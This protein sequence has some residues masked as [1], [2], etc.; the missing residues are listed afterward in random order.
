MTSEG[1]SSGEGDETSTGDSS[2]LGAETDLEPEPLDPAVCDPHRSIEQTAGL[3]FHVTNNTSEQIVMVTRQHRQDAC[4]RDFIGLD[5]A[6]DGPVYWHEMFC[7]SLGNTPICDDYLDGND[8]SVLLC[9]CAYDDDLVIIEPGGEW[10]F[11]W[12]GLALVA[13]D[14]PALCVDASAHQVS[15]NV[16]CETAQKPKVGEYTVSVSFVRGA[17]I[18]CGSQP[19]TCPNGEAS[20]A[21]ESL[22]GS[23]K[24]GMLPDRHEAQASFQWPT[25]GPV[26]IEIN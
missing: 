5:H 12:S 8:V 14:M 7:G 9:V 17:E 10:T 22:Y 18:N 16:W 4:E 6:E 25:D 20:C 26:R 15:G 21:I 23:T 3:D 24:G 11:P 13:H 2:T 1:G 19:C